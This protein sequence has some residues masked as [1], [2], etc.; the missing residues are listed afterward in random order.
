MG[1][2]LSHFALDKIFSYAATVYW[3]DDNLQRY[4]N[5]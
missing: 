1:P 4:T 2:Q 3:R 5:V